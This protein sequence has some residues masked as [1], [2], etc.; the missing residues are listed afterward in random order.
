MDLVAASLSCYQ[1]R[2]A[3][4]QLRFRQLTARDVLV[5]HELDGVFVSAFES[6]EGR[7]HLRFNAGAVAVAPVK[8]PL[9]EQHYGMAQSVA[10]YR[11]PKVGEVLV[12]HRGEDLA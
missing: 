7:F 4:P 12:G 5:S 6:C 2:G 10:R 9:F 3:H 1:H 11:I 8:N